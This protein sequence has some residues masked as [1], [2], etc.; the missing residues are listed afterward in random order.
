MPTPTMIQRILIGIFAAVV[1]STAAQA[2]TFQV[3]KVEDTADGTCDADCSLREAI[4][5]ANQGA[6]QDTILIPDGKY[7][8]TIAGADDDGLLGDFDIKSAVEL[9]GNTQDPGKVIISGGKTERVFDIFN[10]AGVTIRSLRI[11]DGSASTGAGILVTEKSFLFLSAVTLRGNQA[12][13]KGGAVALVSAVYSVIHNSTLTSNSS[14]EDG[15]AIWVDKSPLLI[16]GSRLNTNTSLRGGAV[17]VLDATVTIKQSYFSYNEAESRGG[18]IYINGACN[19]PMTSVSLTHNKAMFGG[20]LEVESGSARLYRSALYYNEAN[21]GGAAVDTTG[22]VHVVSSTIAANKTVGGIG[23]GIYVTSGVATL[24]NASVKRNLAGTGAGVA[25]GGGDVEI[26][27]SLVIFNVA[28]VKKDTQDIYGGSLSKGHNIIGAA[29]PQFQHHKTDL[30]NVV[31]ESESGDIV[32]SDVSGD[33]Y[34][35]VIPVSLA[36]N[37]GDCVNVDGAA[38]LVV[39]Q[40]GRKR[41][42]ACDAGAIEAVCGDGLVIAKDAEECDDGNVKDGDGCSAVCKT[43]KAAAPAPGGVPAPAA[44]GLPEGGIAPAKPG[45][46]A[47]GAATPLGPSEIEG[48]TVPAPAPSTDTQGASSDGANS[49]PSGGSASDAA[50]S[51]GSGGCS[52]IR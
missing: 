23:G 2:A 43:E 46:A 51:G 40:L 19:V 36:I 6:D 20:A 47:S 49:T 11:Q 35:K 3:T 16:L 17:A 10:G 18:A 32:E 14:G 33:S 9:K 44:Q 1:F 15:G 12:S 26:Q 5:A 38:D 41:V 27:N 39:D 25:V 24:T 31:A 48:G 8:I 7:T 4:N 28:P 34:V 29:D 42:N 50:A 13:L 30:L 37:F 21:G 52:L 22:T 45:E